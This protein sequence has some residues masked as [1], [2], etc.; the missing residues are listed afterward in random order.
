MQLRESYREASADQFSIRS[1][2]RRICP[3]GD[4]DLLQ[5]CDFGKELCFSSKIVKEPNDGVNQAVLFN[6]NPI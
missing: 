1:K 3:K 2:S 6:E 4:I 5:G